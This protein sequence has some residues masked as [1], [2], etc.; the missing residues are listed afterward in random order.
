MGKLH[1][2]K[3]KKKGKN[4]R[5]K[6]SW[7]F[8]V[9][10]SKTVVAKIIQLYCNVFFPPC[11]WFSRI[12]RSFWQTQQT[13]TK[14]IY[15]LNT[16]Q[17]KLRSLMRFRNLIAERLISKTV[18]KKQLLSFRFTQILQSDTNYRSLFT[19]YLGICYK[20]FL[21]MMFGW[22]SFL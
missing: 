1:K 22:L 16:K 13:E 14:S 8:K 6:I 15:N 5:K 12:I 21:K 20:M 4:K 17:W 11:S 18:G 2:D 10:L 3:R 19:Q 9:V 7:V